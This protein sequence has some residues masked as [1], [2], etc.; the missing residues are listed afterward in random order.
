MKYTISLFLYPA[1]L[2]AGMSVDKPAPTIPGLR[3]LLEQET[4]LTDKTG[5]AIPN[6]IINVPIGKSVILYRTDGTCYKG[7]VTE[8]EEGDNYFKLYG[9]INNLDEGASF[10][11]IMAKGGNFAGAII[12]KKSNKT[13]VLEFSSEHKGF[14]F[15]L[16]T[17]YDKPSA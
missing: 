3:L 15:V 1:M 16:S 7:T 8:I 9:K 17:K 2:M 6:Q 14:V 13:Y 11:F 5:V 12:E 4:F 10:G